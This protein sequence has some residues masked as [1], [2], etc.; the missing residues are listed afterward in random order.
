MSDMFSGMPVRDINSKRYSF[1]TF[2][3]E[4][5]NSYASKLYCILTERCILCSA[6]SK[7]MCCQESAVKV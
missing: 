4:E 7:D 1:C 5:D 6:R 3:R 2:I